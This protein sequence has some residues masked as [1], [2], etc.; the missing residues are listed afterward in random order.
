M[1]SSSYDRGLINT[2]LAEMDGFNKKEHI[3]V[4]GATN[5]EKDLDPAA[6]R[7]GR[8]D[9]I[10]HVPLPDTKGR[11]DLFD[12]YLKK[13]KLN[14]PSDITSKNLASMT[15]GFSGAEIE[16]MINLA[17]IDAVDKNLIE[18]NRDIL[19]EARD[20]VLLG[21]KRKIKDTN[22]KSLI[23]R[24]IH[25]AGHTIVCYDSP[26]CQDKLHKVSIIPRGESKGKTSVIFSDIQGTKEEFK[27]MIDMA[28]AGLIAEEIYF[29]PDKVSVG[30]GNDLNRATNIAKSMVTKY[31]MSPNFGY[32]V[33]K[34]E[35]QAHRISNFTRDDMDSAVSNILTDSAERV[36]E[37]IGKSQDRLST[38]TKILVEYEE[39]T[40]K[41][42]DLILK[43]NIEEFRQGKG[44][45]KR[46]LDIEKL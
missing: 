21:I 3:F 15:P 6:L 18:V 1:Y 17:I 20:R 44:P 38:L 32:M 29:G 14:L 4:L 24:A 2:F 41:D 5:S 43:G 13:I 42:I 40:K 9:K 37:I 11:Q 35:H 19:E 28:L 30:C 45:K 7:P 27:S 31:A 34:D 12:L 33:V 8:F 23:Q 16:N 10:V 46:D 36:K 22:M 39:I 26:I 25:E